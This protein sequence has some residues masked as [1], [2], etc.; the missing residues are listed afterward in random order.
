MTPVTVVPIVAQPIPVAEATM[1]RYEAA[2]QVLERALHTGPG[3]KDA[4]I[5]YMLALAHKRQGKTQD[6]RNALRK[7]TKPDANVM[8]QMGL[9]SLQEG[10]LVQ[11]E[12]EFARALEMDANSYETCY[13]LL[14]TRLTLGKV[15]DAY[16][17]LPRALELVSGPQANDERRFLLV[18]QA[19]LRCCVKGGS[20]GLDDP[21][22]AALG[23]ADEQRLLKVILSL[24]QL[25][26]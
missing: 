24:G 25:D 22:M 5:A 26:T 8:L 2:A 17:L 15:D 16:S 12:G 4:N 1:S 18:L 11:A 7:I 6:A 19:L 20:G 9:L 10:N 14:L 13:N 3:G 21:V 23:N